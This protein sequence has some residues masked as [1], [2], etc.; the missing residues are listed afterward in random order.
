[1]DL[2]NVTAKMQIGYGSAQIKSGD[3]A[4]NVHVVVESPKAAGEAAAQA[5][6]QLD[7]A[8]KNGAI[9][10]QLSNAVST[11]KIEARRE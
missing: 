8:K 7:E 1:M 10:K 11:I 5:Q 3:I 4:A 6:K 9:P 2:D